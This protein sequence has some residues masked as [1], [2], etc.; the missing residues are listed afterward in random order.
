MALDPIKLDKLALIKRLIN[1]YSE[2]EIPWQEPI[3][4][5]SI[6]VVGAQNE[7]T[8]WEILFLNF[9]ME[10]HTFK[11]YITSKKD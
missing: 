8:I 1:Y 10:K 4:C 5:E 6:C 3:I 2:F 11:L 9:C 7:H